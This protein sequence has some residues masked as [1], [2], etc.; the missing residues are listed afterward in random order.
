VDSQRELV[1]P[2]LR[3]KSRQP[4]GLSRTFPRNRVF[5]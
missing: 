2:L 5:R 1:R 4:A 3:H